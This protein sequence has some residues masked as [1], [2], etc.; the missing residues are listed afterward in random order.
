M[1][2]H[3]P[4]VSREHVLK[5]LAA[6]KVQVQLSESDGITTYSLSKNGTD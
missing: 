5:V 1:D 3:P 6:F 2:N 4:D